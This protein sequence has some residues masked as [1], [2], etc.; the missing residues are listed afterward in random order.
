MNLTE[1]FATLGFAAHE[2]VE[3]LPSEC[4]SCYFSLDDHRW[5][6][7]PHQFLWWQYLLIV[8]FMTPIVVLMV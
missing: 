6:H 8:P 1:A 5:D 2:S 4:C 7:E 3:S